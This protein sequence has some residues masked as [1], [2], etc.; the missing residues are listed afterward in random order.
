[1]KYVHWRLRYWG[2]VLAT[3]GLF[4]FNGCGLSDRQLSSVWEAVITTALN[5]LV[6]NALSSATGAT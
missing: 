4:A 5:T 3:G 2:L 6:G 1:M